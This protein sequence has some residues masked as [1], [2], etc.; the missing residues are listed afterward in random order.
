[1]S[2]ERKRRMRQKRKR[3]KWDGRHKGK[4]KGSRQEKDVDGEKTAPL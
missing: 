2:K 1:M 3:E 4:R